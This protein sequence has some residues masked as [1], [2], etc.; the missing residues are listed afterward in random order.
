[1]INLGEALEASFVH[2]KRSAHSTADHLAK[3]GISCQSLI[4]DQDHVY[5]SLA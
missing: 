4:S 3:E 5:L 1:M 2:A